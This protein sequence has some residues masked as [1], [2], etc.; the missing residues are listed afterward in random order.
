MR[1]IIW[2]ASPKSVTATRLRRAVRAGAD[3]ISVMVDGRAKQRTYHPYDRDRVDACR[4]ALDR[5]HDVGMAAGITVWAQPRAHTAIAWLA[6]NFGPLDHL[7]LDAEEP[8]TQAEDYYVDAPADY[9]GALTGMRSLYVTT[10][11]RPTLRAVALCAAL[12]EI[13]TWI[14]QCY[15]AQHG[16][17]Q[18]A[19]C[20]ALPIPAKS[21][22][23]RWPSDPSVLTDLQQLAGPMRDR[24]YWQLGALRSGM[25]L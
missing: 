18:V 6:A 3:A 2:A 15:S 11:R 5:V 21:R 22:S 25:A 1:I 13:A 24:W 14:P 12:D 19:V 9:A 4:D 17:P 8:W 16:V 10:L 20:A 23:G 7:C